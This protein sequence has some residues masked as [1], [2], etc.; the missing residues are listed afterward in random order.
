MKEKYQVLAI[1][2]KGLDQKLSFKL[3]MNQML[4]LMGVWVFDWCW[5]MGQI[6][7]KIF[8]KFVLDLK[9][10]N[11]NMMSF[12]GENEDPLEGFVPQRDNMS[13]NSSIEVVGSDR[14]Q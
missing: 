14:C 9:D 12:L 8:E 2:L 3:N 11:I 4:V 1:V 7:P 13:Y 10:L 5:L 6:K